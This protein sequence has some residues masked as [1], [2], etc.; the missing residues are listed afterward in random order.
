MSISRR[1]LHWLISPVGLFLGSVAVIIALEEWRSAEQEAETKIEYAKKEAE[2]LAER[3]TR[4]KVTPPL[5]KAIQDKD[6]LAVRAAIKQG[7]DPNTPH[8]ETT[9]LRAAFMK[10]AGWP[11]KRDVIEALLDGGANINAQAKDGYTALHIVVRRSNKE[12]VELLLD[13]GAEVNAKTKD[14]KTALMMAERIEIAELLL[15]RGAKWGT[16]ESAIDPEGT[17]IREAARRGDAKLIELLVSK[18]ADPNRKSKG[19][20]TPLLSAVNGR[21]TEAVR[22]LL[23]AGAKADD[24]FLDDNS[25]LH[26]AA[27]TNR[28]DIAKLL[29]A[30]GADVN[31]TRKSGW[32]PLH[33]ASANCYEEFAE[34][35]IASGANRNALDK[36]GKAPLPCYAFA[37]KASR[38]SADLIV[39]CRI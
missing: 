8:R 12:L 31:A 3:A 7:A 18:G 27:E 9:P 26:F 30:A 33:I 11:G 23:A 19:G 5:F 2:W 1:L 37:K 29:I 28:I 13:R 20:G 38:G 25:V 4:E 16:G 35:L 14:G 39:S 15:A 17:R 6:A 10:D 21:H 34:L 36:H 22:A 32:T 24:R